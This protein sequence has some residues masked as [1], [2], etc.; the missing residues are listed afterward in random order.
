MLHYRNLLVSTVCLFGLSLFANPQDWRVS[1]EKAR[2]KADTSVRETQK[3]G[4]GT[5]NKSTIEQ[6]EADLAA[7][8]HFEGD[9]APESALEAG[10]TLANYRRD[11]ANGRGDR[12]P[13]WSKDKITLFILNPDGPYQAPARYLGVKRALAKPGTPYRNGS[14]LAFTRD[15]VWFEDVDGTV[16][17]IATGLPAEENVAGAYVS[18]DVKKE[19]DLQRAVAKL[20]GKKFVYVGDPKPVRM[21]AR[22]G[23]LKGLF[24]DLV[25]SKHLVSDNGDSVN[26]IDS[27]KA[28]RSFEKD[29]MFSGTDAATL[30]GDEIKEAVSQHMNSLKDLPVAWNGDVDA[31]LQGDTSQLMNDAL[32]HAIAQLG[33]N[34]TEGREFAERMTRQSLNSFPNNSVSDEELDTLLHKVLWFDKDHENPEMWES[35]LEGFRQE[36][37]SSGAHGT[38]AARFASILENR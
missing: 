14:L 23:D 18:A 2:Y 33:E 13:S 4:S 22:A 29:Q 27:K 9:T 1:L 32:A 5:M 10:R 20:L 12:L 26:V 35:V 21:E 8:L 7:M 3:N 16:S 37:Q 6:L 31:L 36:A 34:P 19:S 11:Y 25:G 38:R 28:A 17:V 30:S 24:G 15:R